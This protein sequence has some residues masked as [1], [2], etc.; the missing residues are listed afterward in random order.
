MVVLEW[1]AKME[2]G[3]NILKNIWKSV[4]KVLKLSILPQSPILLLRIHLQA[5]K[6]NTIFKAQLFA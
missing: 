4:L 5:I 2:I 3:T 6:Q 1:L